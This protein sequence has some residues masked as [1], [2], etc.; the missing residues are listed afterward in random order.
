M[1]N[2]RCSCPGWVHAGS[3]PAPQPTRH[4]MQAV[5]VD[6]S[7]S[8]MEGESTRGDSSARGG[9]AGDVSPHTIRDAELRDMPALQ[10]VFQEASLS[11]AGDRA[12]LL[13]HPD[14][15]ELS[16]AAVRDGRT[17]VATIGDEVVGF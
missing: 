10:R 6:S 2:C 17:R 16:D 3:S 5:T 15:L 14:V 1:T 13:A 4:S 11:N 9:E 12:A 7:G 8:G